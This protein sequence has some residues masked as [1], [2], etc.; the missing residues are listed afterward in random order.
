MPGQR[1]R[2]RGGAF[3]LKIPVTARQRQHRRAFGVACTSEA[4]RVVEPGI[5]GI[6]PLEE[7]RCL[8]RLAPGRFQR[9]V[10][11]GCVDQ[12]QLGRTDAAERAV[13]L[14]TQRRGQRQALHAVDALPRR[15][16]RHVDLGVREARTL[17]AVDG[18]DA[19]DVVGIAELVAPVADACGKPRLACGQREER[20]FNAEFVR[21]ALVAV[22]DVADALH[23]GGRDRLQ[24]VLVVLATAEGTAQGQRP[25]PGQPH[26]DARRYEGHRGVRRHQAVAPRPVVKMPL[27]ALGAQRVEAQLDGITDQLVRAQQ[28]AAHVAADKG[29]G[30]TS[31]SV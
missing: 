14:T 4:D 3:R 24:P 9:E 8:E 17:A 7:G 12:P 22:A 26:L 21:P 28:S 6:V 5:R 25:V 27:V 13:V 18:V 19:G 30:S 16:Q 20:A 15:D 29:D 10:L 31:C 1:H 23:P 2:A 11:G